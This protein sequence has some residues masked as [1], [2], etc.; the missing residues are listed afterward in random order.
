MEKKDV[1]EL[2]R[3]YY[4]SGL[5]CAESILHALNDT[6][7]LE[8]SDDLLKA[9]TGFGTGFGGKGSTCGAITGSIMALSLKHGRLKPEESFEDAYKPAKAVADAYERNYG[10]TE[11]AE[12]TRS[13][14]EKGQFKTSERQRFCGDIVLCMARETEKLLT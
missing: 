14:R 8:V 4:S 5:G 9:A 6:G 3:E 1:G 10:S 11:C 7:I 13:W 2:A 12:V